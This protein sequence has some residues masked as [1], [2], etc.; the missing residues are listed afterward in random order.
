MI[1]YAR[2]L[3][4][5][6]QLLI[7][8]LI[9]GAVGFSLTMWALPAKAVDLGVEGAVYEPIEEDLRIA[10]L[11]MIA[12]ED[13]RPMQQALL[14]SAENF[15]K[16]LPSYYLPRA[17]KTVTR[18]KD[19]GAEVTEDIF[20]PGVPDW[21][22]GSVRDMKPVLLAK[23]GTYVNMISDL[24]VEA[25][26]RIFLFDATD[27]DQL[28]LAKEVAAA[29]LDHLA[30]IA[31]AGDVKE[32]SELMD[33]PVFHPGN[34]LLTQMNVRAVPSLLGFGKGWH[35][36]HI[37]ITEFAL[38]SSVDEVKRAWFGLASATDVSAEKKD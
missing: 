33:G 35:Q 11:R 15:T 10:M 12:K 21:E 37:A 1:R 36:G 38:P 4:N 9:G 5:K 28:Q 25:I 24:P 18:W 17:E 22:N 6:P 7:R 26:P 19:A 23:K 31:I 13:L 8:F 34:Q 3:F 14:Q 29:K 30:L 20:I 2:T 32:L 27:P 16:E